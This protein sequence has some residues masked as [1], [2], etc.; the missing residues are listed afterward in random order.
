LSLARR[1]NASD[2]A[3]GADLEPPVDAATLARL[4]V[5]SAGGRLEIRPDGAVA[6]I[7]ATRE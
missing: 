4:V 5:E 3:V 7:P 6:G 2:G 1:R